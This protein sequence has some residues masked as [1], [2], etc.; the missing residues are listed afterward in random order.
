[1]IVG[2]FIGDGLSDFLIKEV[3]ENALYSIECNQNDLC[4]KKVNMISKDVAQ[5]LGMQIY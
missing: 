4:T 3:V 2:I 5:K 1:M